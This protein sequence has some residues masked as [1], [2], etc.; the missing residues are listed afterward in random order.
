[1]HTAQRNN[2][3]QEYRVSS[4]KHPTSI[5]HHDSLFP[6]IPAPARRSLG[7]GGKAGIYLTIRWIRIFHIPAFLF[8]VSSLLL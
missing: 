7:E 2:A 5:E 4:I 6:V 8:P 3:Q 1:M